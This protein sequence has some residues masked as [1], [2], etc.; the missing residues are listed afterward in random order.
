MVLKLI[1]NRK[2]LKKQLVLKNVY[3]IK[4]RII[5]VEF[6]HLNKF[7]NSN[8]YKYTFES[9]LCQIISFSI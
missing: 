1:E 4:K 5:K 2:F 7:P 9:F 3:F 8:R 6:N